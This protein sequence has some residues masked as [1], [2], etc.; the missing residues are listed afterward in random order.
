MR[1]PFYLATTAILLLWLSA[2]CNTNM[3][4]EKNTEIPNSLWDYNNLLPF[5]TEI[6]DTTSRYHLFVNVRHTNNYAYS[7]LWVKIYTTLPSG[8]KMEQRVELPLSDKQG[9]WYGK[10]SGSIIQQQVSIQSTAI[11]P[12]VGKYGF[13]IEQNMRLNPLPEV[14]SIGLSIEKATP[15]QTDKK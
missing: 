13:Q 11:M 12:E 4:F 2:G 9:K 14:L 5:E 10:D 15:P 1:F 7:N 8:K 3:V 6:T